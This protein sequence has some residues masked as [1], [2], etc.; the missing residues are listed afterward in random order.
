MNN[1][2]FKIVLM[3]AKDSVKERSLFFVSISKAL[4]EFMK[5]I[6]KYI[7]YENV[8][9]AGKLKSSKKKNAQKTTAQT[10]SDKPPKLDERMT[11]KVRTKSDDSCLKDK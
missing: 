7:N 5:K 8:L 2:Q 10:K 4:V 6:E 3:L 11:Y 9:E 1:L